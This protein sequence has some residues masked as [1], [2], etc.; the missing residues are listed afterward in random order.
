MSDLIP[1]PAPAAPPDADERRR[2]DRQ[3]G[4]QR[5]AERALRQAALAL[6]LALAACVAATF[7]GW[8]VLA[9][10][11]ALAR[12]REAARLALSDLATIRGRLGQIETRAAAEAAALDALAPLP[13]QLAALGERFASVEARIAAPQ[14]SVARVEAAELVELAG[15]RL[16]FEHDVAGAIA[17]YTAAA[18]RLG[19]V[20]DPSLEAVRAQLERE[21]Q[22]LRELP[23]PDV[24][25][26]GRRLTAAG[27]EVEQLPMLGMIQNQYL[28][29][30][31]VASPEPGLR[32]AWQNFT[33]SLKDLISIRR[34]SDA[35]VELASMEEI[36]VRRQHLQTLLLIARLAAFRGDAAEYAIS[37]GAARDW[38]ERFYD[39]HDARV[40][41]LTAELGE[42]AGATVSPP[43]PKLGTTLRMLRGS[44]R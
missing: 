6:L 10:E 33:I 28:P 16:A 4:D 34:V 15:D 32:R 11:R 18:T 27:A 37:V 5:R 2:A 23:T 14:R 30:G 21:L 44:R 17:L 24:A 9:L 25:A 22:M 35:S 39:S 40:R 38:L 1:P 31:T 12:D 43:L 20:N 7:A 3:R 26:I 8:R 42:L 19:A 29:P 41:R 13:S 36:G